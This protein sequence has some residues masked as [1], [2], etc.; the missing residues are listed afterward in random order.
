MATP[1]YC[2]ADDVAR[3]LQTEPFSA[4]TT[5]TTT[6]VENIINRKEDR[7]DQKLMH[8]WREKTVTDLFLD[9]TFIEIRNGARFDVPNYS[10]KTLSSGSGD[11]L[12]VWDGTN[13]IDFLTDKTE[14]RDND[15][16]VDLN[17]GIIWIRVNV[18]VATRKPI[19]VTYR[20]GETVVTGDIEDLC[21]NMA[22]IDIL[23]MY[24][25]NI[26]MVD[27]GGSAAPTSDSRIANMKEEIKDLW[28]TLSNI[29]TF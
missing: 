17:K 29:G 26:R 22:A 28:I 1:V 19:R 23:N 5:P 27:D 7:I 6:Q 3:L 4:S 18:R 8:G 25:R 9:T 12:E 16:W 21:V 14:G 10:L 20:F 13:Y 11:K 24:Q 2:T 15:Y